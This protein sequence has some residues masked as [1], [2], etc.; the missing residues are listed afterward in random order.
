MI[1]FKHA[2]PAKKA[3]KKEKAKK[4]GSIHY[5]V[6]YCIVCSKGG[7]LICCER[8]PSS[9]HTHCVGLDHLPD[10]SYLCSECTLG[11]SILYGDIVWVNMGNYRSDVYIVSESMKLT[12]LNFFSRWWPGRVYPLNEIPARHQKYQPKAGEF[13]VFFFGSKDSAFVYRGQVFHYQDGV[14]S[15]STFPYVM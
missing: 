3:G 9:L 8:C 5:N 14:S 6:D 15:F 2:V 4:G 10:G 7:D 11:K 12:F 1:C 13:L